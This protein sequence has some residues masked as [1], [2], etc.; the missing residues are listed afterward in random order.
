MPINSEIVVGDTSL[1]TMN[2]DELV[3]GIIVDSKS[4]PPTQYSNYTPRYFHI[5]FF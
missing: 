2:C 5:Q 4:M 3:E 1:D